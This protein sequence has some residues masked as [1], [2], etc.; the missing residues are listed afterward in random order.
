[1]SSRSCLLLAMLVALLVPGGS[2]GD[3]L[4]GMTLSAVLAGMEKVA[5]P[6]AES[7]PPA[8]GCGSAAGP[9]FGSIPSPKVEVLCFP[10]TDLLTE[11][12]AAFRREQAAERERRRLKRERERRERVAKRR[13]ERR[14]KL[15]ECARYVAQKYAAPGEAH[16]LRKAPPKVQEVVCAA[17]EIDDTIYSYGGG[18]P[19]FDPGG[20][21]ENGGPGYDC[22]GAVSYAL[23]G[24][25]FIESSLNSEGLEKW[26]QGGVGQWITVYA[27]TAHA[28]MVVAGVRFDTREPPEE[29]TGPRWHST[30]SSPEGYVARHPSG[31]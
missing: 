31:Y 25:G 7:R 12:V 23:R 20:N 16:L 14:L 1:M 17:N 6:P 28:W 5:P 24:G 3:E 13:A 10:G 2:Y 11:T 18:H 19:G 26:G 15:A 4:E 22:S 29:E 21:E 8:T 27:N 30:S 9:A